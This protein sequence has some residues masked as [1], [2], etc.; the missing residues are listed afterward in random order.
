MTFDH[1]WSRVARR[2]TCCLEEGALFVEVPETEVHQLDIIVVVE[3]DVLWLEVSMHNADLVDVLD[4]RDYLLVVLAGLI[5]LEALGLPDLLE[6]LVPATVLH[7]Q[8][9]VL[10]VLNDLYRV[11][12]DGS[13]VKE[14][15]YVRVTKLLKNLDLAVDSLEIRRVLDHRLVKNLDRRLSKFQ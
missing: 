2:A 11:E 14:L 7:D 10:I 8:E 12:R 1:L 3:K 6:E 4:T 5:F 9:E 13:Y 15:D